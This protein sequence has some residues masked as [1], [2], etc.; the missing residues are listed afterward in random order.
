MAECQFGIDFTGSA[1]DLV[2][3]A[4]KE[5]EDHGGTFQ[6]DA[7]S[8]SFSVSVPILGKIEGAYTIKGQTINVTITKKPGL[9]SCGAIES[10]LK[11]YLK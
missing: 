7:S 4:K 1:E 6:G 11:K 8:G 2:K 10:Q 5:I 9:L 3:R